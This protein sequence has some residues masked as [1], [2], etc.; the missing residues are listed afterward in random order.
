MNRIL[1]FDDKNM[2]VVV[3]PYVSFAQVQAEAQKRGLNCHVIAAGCQPSFL[4]RM[5]SV[6]GTNTQAI[7]HGW[8]GRNLLGVEWVL[9]TG[10]IL[11][12]GA[13]GSGAGWFSG[14]G[15]GPSLRGIMRGSAG[16]SGGLG[17]FTKC[18]AHLH[19]WPGPSEMEIKGISPYYETVVPPLFKYL[20]YE[21][22][23]WEEC[24]DALYKIGE[25]GIAF[26]MH[27]TAGPGTHGATISGSNNEFY[28]QYQKHPE[29]QLPWVSYAIVLAG[30]SE[31]E[32]EYQ[33]KVLERIMGETG[34]KYLPLSDDPTWR[35]RDYLNMIRMCFVP[36]TAFRCTGAFAC[37]L[38]GMESIQHTTFGL[39]LDK[40]F[41]RKYDAR[42][43]LGDDGTNNM[44]GVPFEGGHWSIFECG[45]F[46]DPADK[47]SFKGMEE[48]MQEGKEIGI[49]TP[50]GP[51]LLGTGDEGAREYGPLRYNF[52]KWMQKVKKTFDPNLA[53]DPSNY[54]W[55][56]DK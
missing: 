11:R 34:G 6:Q 27:K 1:D 4:A 45:H 12:L 20:M 30:N 9:P 35:N 55:P 44:W 54:I 51:F 29:W 48:M 40:E 15:P 37:P 32:Q 43:V 38:Q 31:Q 2:Y 53:S 8:S 52:H 50:L 46:Y 47:H 24:A 42:D 36:R 56:D 23:T 22:P 18:A 25:A 5:T 28:E 26:A 7:S 17:V 3:E 21:W 49:K 39:S 13:L 19:P 16:A 10:D 41:R 14:D 33:L